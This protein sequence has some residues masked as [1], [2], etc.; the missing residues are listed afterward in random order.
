M[1]A[2]RQ[3]RVPEHPADD[4]FVGRWSPRAFAPDP[5]DAATLSTL[6][7]AAR[8]SPSCFN[9]QPWLFV[10]A[11]KDEDRVRF[12]ASLMEGNR[13]WAESAPALAY[14]FARRRFE[15][16]DKPN[17]HAGFDAGAAWMSLAL[18]A[19]LLGLCTHAMAGFD[20]AAAHA[21]TGVPE[22][23]WEVMAAIAIGRMGD[24]ATLPEP[25]RQRESP[26]G[27]KPWSAVAV[28]GRLC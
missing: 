18:Q 25:L 12:A 10:Y 2:G 22:A 20:A 26:S 14:V 23:E 27:R 13:A 3:G 5:V 7:E 6:F 24:A 15:R 17:R 28:E 11:V 21:A 16:N 8:W 9:E 4:L 19:R 1:S